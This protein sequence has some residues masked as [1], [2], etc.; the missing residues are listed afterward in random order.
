MHRQLPELRF[1]GLCH[2]IASLRHHLPKIL[3]TPCENLRYR[4]AGLNHFR[5]LLEVSYRDTG[6]DAYPDIREK[7]PAFFDKLPDL[8]SVIRL[9]LES[10]AGSTPGSEPALRPGARSWAERGL[11][12]VLLE[13]FG[14]MPITTDSHLGEYVQWAHD[15][16]DHKGILDFYTYYKQWTQ[17]SRP[18][19]EMRLSERVVPIME[20]ILTDERYEEAAVN[21]PNAGFIEQLP[22]FIVVEVPAMIDS[23]GVQG[24][25]LGELPS[26]F[27]G[28]LRNQVAVHDLTAEAII[29]RSRDLALQALLVDPVIDAFGATEQML[30]TMIELQVDYL[31]YLE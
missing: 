11:F 30:D 25:A 20:A 19:I 10:R 26:G 6:R 15:V 17:R 31:G 13:T 21:V 12:R 27:A 7:A 28:L 23:S 24:I 1:V 16:V 22:E 4:A 8:G 29:H 5:V 2:E 3:D 18:A 9:L 14:Y